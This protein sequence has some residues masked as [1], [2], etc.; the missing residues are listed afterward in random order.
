M[1][2]TLLYNKKGQ[3]ESP[4]SAYQPSAAIRDLTVL[5]KQAYQDG[6]NVQTMPLQ[7][8]NGMSLITRANESQRAWLSHPDEPYE[9]EDEWRWN[10][11]RPIT[12]NRVIFT[13][14]RLTRQ[15]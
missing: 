5:V 8:Y 1:L 4:R 12:R 15:L 7:E 2:G 14:A 10:G 3:V 11:V 6:E 13:A 9:G